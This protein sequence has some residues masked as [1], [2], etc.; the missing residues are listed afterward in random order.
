MYAMTGQPFSEDWIPIRA[1]AERSGL[2]VRRV[3]QLAYKGLV[4]HHYLHARM[5][6]VFWPEVGQHLSEMQALGKLKHRNS[7]AHRVI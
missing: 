4:R 6:L 5:L 1:A 2:S 3:R 7:R